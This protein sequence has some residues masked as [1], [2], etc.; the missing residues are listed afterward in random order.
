MSFMNH[1]SK[2]LNQRV[3][4][5]GTPNFIAKLDRSMTILR[6]QY[7]QLASEEKIVF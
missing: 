4:C 6:T 1:F 7:L 3:G 2:L 5:V